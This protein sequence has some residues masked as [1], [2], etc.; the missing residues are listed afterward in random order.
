MSETSFFRQLTNSN[1]SL[2]WN[3]HAS[4]AMV[5]LTLIQYAA[6]INS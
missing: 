6:V 1:M 2:N 4:K 3:S 5:D